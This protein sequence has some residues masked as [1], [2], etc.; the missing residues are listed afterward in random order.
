ML[1]I[2]PRE[3]QKLQRLENLAEDIAA[4]RDVGA[5]KVWECSVFLCTGI[6]LGLPTPTLIVLA[7]SIEQVQI[8]AY[9]VEFQALDQSNRA[10]LSA[11]RHVYCIGKT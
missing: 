3:Q 8:N 5:L 9:T 2:R 11:G 10:R 7:Q 6:S 1:R 4:R